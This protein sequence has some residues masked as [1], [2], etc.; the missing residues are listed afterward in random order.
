MKSLDV[1]CARCTMVVTGAKKG[2][3]RH[4]THANNAEQSY[5]DEGL[6]IGSLVRCIA[7]V[8]SLPL[9]GSYS[10]SPP[11]SRIGHNQDGSVSKVPGE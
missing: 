8:T 1:T 4:P 2:M 10:L 7:R 5:Y 11:R 6:V 3:E 9:N